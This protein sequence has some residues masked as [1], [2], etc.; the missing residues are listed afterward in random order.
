MALA[1][2]LAPEPLVLL[3]DEPF[4]ALDQSL[5]QHLRREVRDLQRRTGFTAL[6]VTHSQEEALS[7]SDRMLIMGRG[8]VEQVGSPDEL[9]HRPGTPY[10]AGF[11]GEMNRL[12]ARVSQAG[13]RIELDGL[14]FPVPPDKTWPEGP[15]FLCFRPE[16]GQIAAAPGEGAWL[17]VTVVGREFAG[18]T[19]RLQAGGRGGPP[20]SSTLARTRPRPSPIRRPG[21]DCR[22][23]GRAL[24]RSQTSRACRA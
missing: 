1:R 13:S 16:D 7:L 18:P 11:L 10:V 23:S 24:R 12:P 4:S 21:C 5:R 14:L 8:R 15:G 19:I 3:F 2:A 6:F 20:K 22:S 9:Y 17:P